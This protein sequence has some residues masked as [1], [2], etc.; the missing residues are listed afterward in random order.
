[1]SHLI[2]AIDESMRS[3][4]YLMCA[5]VAS[6][7]DRPHLRQLLRALLL[8][9][10][11]RLHAKRESLGRKRS[12]LKSFADLP[13]A[14]C[15][16][17]VGRNSDES[18]RQECLEALARHLLALRVEELV[19]E[20]CDDGTMRRDAATMERLGSHQAITWRHE[21]PEAEPMLWI[22]DLVLNAFGLGGD[23][24]ETAKAHVVSVV[25]LG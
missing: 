5:T 25:E 11:R 23:L 4:C 10:Q 14:G 20:R 16:L 9:G 6:T 15:H 12:L 17:V 2:A 18:G 21:A 22:S 1:M 3:N 13:I 19:L 24:R 7:N 8:P